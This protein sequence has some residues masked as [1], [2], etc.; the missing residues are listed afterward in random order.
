MIILM[1]PRIGGA[2]S[3]IPKLRSGLKG[4]REIADGLLTK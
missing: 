2:G 3:C 1:V 4:M